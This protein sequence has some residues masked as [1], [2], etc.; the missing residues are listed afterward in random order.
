MGVPV[1]MSFGM[2][3]DTLV[4]MPVGVLVERVARWP[5]RCPWE[6]CMKRG[7]ST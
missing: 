4:G 2:L 3:V 7:N 6:P 1:S 5:R